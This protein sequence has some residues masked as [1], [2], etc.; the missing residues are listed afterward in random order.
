ML[1]FRIKMATETSKKQTICTLNMFSYFH[2]NMAKYF[3]LSPSSHST[4]ELVP[5]IV[6]T[7]LKEFKG[8]IV[9]CSNKQVNALNFY[10][11]LSI[12]LFKIYTRTIL[13]INIFDQIYIHTHTHSYQL[14]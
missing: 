8:F 2:T 11:V 10:L 3:L 4:D 9:I 6:H 14:G 5:C 1:K 13:Y 7:G 12:T